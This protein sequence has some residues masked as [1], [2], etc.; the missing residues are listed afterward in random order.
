M[1]LF[2]QVAVIAVVA[3]YLCACAGLTVGFLLWW[4]VNR[5]RP[6]WGGYAWLPAM[7]VISPVVIAIRVITLTMSDARD[8]PHD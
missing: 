8:T 5:R 7:L 2:G 1:M 4:K 3:T 6:W